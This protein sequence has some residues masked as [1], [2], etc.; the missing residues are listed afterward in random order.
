VT[1][2]V[3][4][5]GLLVVNGLE[6]DYT[7]PLDF[8]LAPYGL[9]GFGFTGNTTILD[10][11]S[12]GIAPA[13][14]TGIPPLAYNV[15]GYYDHNGASVRVSYVWNDKAYASGSNTQSVCLPSTAAQSVGCPG[16]AYLFS[17]PYG[18]MDISSSYRLANIFGDLPTD[19]ELTFDIQN[20]LSAKL[21]TYDQYT[22]AI[23][24]YYNQG[25]VILFGFRGTF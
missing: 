8:L 18:Q 22:N 19:P 23:H 16:G 21:K 12:T 14:A 9:E 25:K 6:F 3:N 1:E 24:S 17:A 15:T 4:E 7:Q 13:F 5:P 11:H 10:Q 20:V 2:Q